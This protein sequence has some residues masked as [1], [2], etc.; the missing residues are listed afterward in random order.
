MTS[1]L[2]SNPQY[3]NTLRIII[4]GVSHKDSYNRM[5]CTLGF[6]RNG[7]DCAWLQEWFLLFSVTVCIEIGVVARL[8]YGWAD[9]WGMGFHDDDQKEQI[10]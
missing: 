5:I 7:E 8:K 6:L 10:K 9:C 1:I 2:S 3:I 4:A